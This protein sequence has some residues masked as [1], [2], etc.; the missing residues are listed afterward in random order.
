MSSRINLLN[1]FSS[2][3]LRQGFKVAGLDFKDGRRERMFVE[4]IVFIV[5]VLR[6]S[7]DCDFGTIDTITGVRENWLHPI[8]ISQIFKFE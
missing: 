3:N 2:L 6:M 4:L 8:F 1:G 7:D 5:S